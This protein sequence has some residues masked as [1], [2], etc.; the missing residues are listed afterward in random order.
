MYFLLIIWIGFIFVATCTRDV[1][2]FIQQGEIKFELTGQPQWL[3]FFQYFP[4]NA[5]EFELFGHVFMFLLLTLLLLTVFQSK[6]FVVL[7]AII[8]G[9]VTEIA[10]LFFN[11]GGVFYDF[12]AD[13]IGVGIGLL[14]FAVL[15]TVISNEKDIVES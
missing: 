4:T 1:H 12:A 11:R 5:S 8:Y 15:K 10:Q 7:L 3:D 13:V 14:V 9:L 2:A 6:R